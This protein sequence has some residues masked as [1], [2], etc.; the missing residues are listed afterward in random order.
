MNV[1]ALYYRV[2]CISSLIWKLW[3]LASL[4]L[5][6]L[7]LSWSLEKMQS[8]EAQ[9]FCKIKEHLFLIFKPWL[10]RTVSQGKQPCFHRSFG[11]AGITFIL[12]FSA[13]MLAFHMKQK[14]LSH[15]SVQKCERHPGLM[16]R[17]Q[18][19]SFSMCIT[20]SVV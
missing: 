17:D 18:N 9:C 7:T 16:L 8:S 2:V 1:L 20:L 12:N 14:V 10:A 19:S 11:T 5:V 4:L 15:I 3:K 13:I 6:L